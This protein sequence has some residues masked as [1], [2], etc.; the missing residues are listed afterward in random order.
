MCDV[1]T[2]ISVNKKCRDC[3]E[4]MYINSYKLSRTSSI[5]QIKNVFKSLQ[6][7]FITRLDKE[8]YLEKTYTTTEEKEEI[9]DA[10]VENVEFSEEMCYPKPLIDDHKWM[11]TKA[12][13]LRIT[14]D[15]IDALSLNICDFVQLR[16]LFVSLTSSYSDTY[17]TLSVVMAHRTLRGVTLCGDIG[18]LSKYTSFP[19]DEHYETKYTFVLSKKNSQSGADISLFATLPNNT[20]VFVT[21]LSKE[22]LKFK[23]VNYEYRQTTPR[24]FAD[25]DMSSNECDIEDVMNKSL[26]TSL[27]LSSYGRDVDRLNKSYAFFDFRKSGTIKELNI[28]CVQFGYIG[29]PDNIEKLCVVASSCDVDTTHC[30]LKELESDC[31]NGSPMDIYDERLV[32]VSIFNNEENSSKIRFIHNNILI[33]NNKTNKK[34]QSRLY[35]NENENNL[36][37][38]IDKYK[39]FDMS[40]WCL[41]NTTVVSKGKVVGDFKCRGIYYE[42]ER[43][44]KLKVIDL[45][46]Y[47]DI[48]LSGI[49]V[50]EVEHFGEEYTQEYPSQLIVGEMKK[51]TFRGGVYSNITVGRSVEIAFVD[52]TVETLNIWKIA[53][54]ESRNSKFE[55]I[56]FTTK[57]EK[58]IAVEKYRLSYEG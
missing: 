41:Y 31:Y 54:F 13:R 22:T 32:R 9:N 23:Y 25:T 57:I 8:N 58:D 52:T 1:T 14:S 38:D 44:K 55:N 5:T 48:S 42:S 39:E 37:V 10:T 30:K 3:V 19:F 17:N 33:N 29:V 16:F 51:A 27:R 40:D 11:H 47:L 34:C 26:S 28:E 45:D 24:V 6:T 2:F 53:D 50:L 36:V 12:R 35:D 18:V 20:E 21:F 49:E 43:T 46:G 7:L 56:N 4:T 15:Q